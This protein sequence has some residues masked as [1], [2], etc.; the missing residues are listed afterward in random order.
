MAV[1]RLSF[2]VKPKEIYALIGPNGAGKT[3][4]LKIIVGL[5]QKTSGEVRLFGDDVTRD[6]SARRTLIG[7]IPD[8]PVFY[9]YLTGR[10]FLDFIRIL[11]EVPESVF[12]KKLTELLKLYPIEDILRE[13]PDRFSRGNKQK[14]SIISALVHNPKLLVVDEPIVGLD[15]QSA[16][17]TADMFRK[18]AEGGGMILVSTHTLSF[19]ETVAST[20]GIIHHG[21]RIFEGSASEISRGSHADKSFTKTLTALMNG[22]A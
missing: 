20:V 19:V 9:P 3:T 4:T 1:D 7:Y 2:T 18:F 10:E 13:Y 15:P 14:L 16:Q 12:K 11:Y 6:A 5:Y 8:E 22:Y 17:V 21:R